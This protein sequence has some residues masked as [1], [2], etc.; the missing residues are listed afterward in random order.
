MRYRID[1]ICYIEPL[2]LVETTTGTTN[3]YGD[4]YL[5]AHFNL[6]SR[7]A[8]KQYHRQGTFFSRK[9]KSKSTVQRLLVGDQRPS[10]LESEFDMAAL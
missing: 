1:K 2:K 10:V 5:G 6:G 7:D 3:P 4:V 8:Y 9:L